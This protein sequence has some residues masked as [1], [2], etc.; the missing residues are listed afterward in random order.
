MSGMDLTPWA[1]A[2]AVSGVLVGA[3]LT[4][5]TQW[6]TRRQASEL[7]IAQQ[8]AS[9]RNDRREAIYNFISTA[10]HVHQ[11]VARDDKSARGIDRRKISQ[12][13]P[14]WLS[15]RNVLMLYAAQNCERLH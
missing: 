3:M 8:K 10:E 2:I 6:L 7:S 11:I 5:V 14:S 1:P 4:F 9:L 15:A 13:T 12:P